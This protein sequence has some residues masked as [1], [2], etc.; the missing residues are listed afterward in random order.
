MAITAGCQSCVA[1]SLTLSHSLTLSLTLSPSER[2]R[3]EQSSNNIDI[4]HFHSDGFGDCLLDDP[5]QAM[6]QSKLARLR[7]TQPGQIYD[8]NQQCE[9]AFGKGYKICPF[10]VGNFRI[11]YF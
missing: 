7:N 10:L 1:N 8:V 4:V 11:K 3:H 6:Y 2:P 9:Q 5:I